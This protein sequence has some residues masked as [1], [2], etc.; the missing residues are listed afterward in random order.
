MAAV[1]A[2]N[3]WRRG[4]DWLFWHRRRLAAHRRDVQGVCIRRGREL[5]GL[6][7][8]RFDWSALLLPAGR[9][10]LKAVMNSYQSVIRCLL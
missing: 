2:A 1:A 7:T 6:L 5:A 3:G 10:L 9:G 4:W 8:T